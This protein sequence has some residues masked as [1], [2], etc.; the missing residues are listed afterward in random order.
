MITCFH[1]CGVRALIC[2]FYALT[3][4]HVIVCIICDGVDVRRRLGAA[5]ALVGGD[6]GGRV[7]RQPFV[8]IHRHTEEPRVGLRKRGSVKTSLGDSHNRGGGG[9]T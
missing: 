7:D 3:S 5:F 4:Q 9:L 6:H 2:R 8:G 1:S